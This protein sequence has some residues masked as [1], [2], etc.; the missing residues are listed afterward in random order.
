[1]SDDERHSLGEE[2]IAWIERE[3]RY[4]EGALVGQPIKLMEWQRDAILRIYDNPATRRACATATAPCSK[5]ALL[6]ASLSETRLVIG[7]FARSARPAG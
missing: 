4:P 2:I 5:S 7:S 1:M 3:C 6:I